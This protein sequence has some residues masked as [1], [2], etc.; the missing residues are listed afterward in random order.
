VILPELEVGVAEP[1]LTCLGDACFVIVACKQL[2]I[3]VD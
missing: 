1:L 2:H 3:C